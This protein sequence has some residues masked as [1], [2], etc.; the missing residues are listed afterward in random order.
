M[1]QRNLDA[2]PAGA[3]PLLRAALAA[4]VQ[5][6]QPAAAPGMLFTDDHAPIE[7]LTDS[8]LLRFLLQADGAGL[9]S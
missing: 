2:L 4:G 5:A 9:D 3:D 1:L 6:L 8:I 7:Q